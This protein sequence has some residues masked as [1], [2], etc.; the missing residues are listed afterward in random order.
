M[1]I[2]VSCATVLEY[3]STLLDAIAGAVLDSCGWTPASGERVLVKPNLVSKT[4][5]PLSCTHGLVV[6][7]A[8]TWLL[9][10]GAKV[11]VA[12]SPAFGSAPSVAR[13]AGLTKALD[14]LGIKVTGLGDPISRETSFGA[15]IGI[16]RTALE[17]DT[18]VNLP[19][20]KAHCQ[21]RI[22][23]AVKNLFGCVTGLRKA[24]A[25]ARFG[26]KGNQFEA[27]ILDVAAMLPRTISLVDAIHPMHRDGPVGGDRYELGLLAA[28]P[29]PIALDTAIYTLLD[30]NSDKVPLWREAKNR[31]LPGA[32][33][34]DLVF[35]MEP[36]SNFD[37]PGFIIPDQLRE[38]SFAPGRLIK[39]RVKS[40]LHRIS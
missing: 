32:D 12:D 11:T 39:G 21:M 9:D 36:L 33:F 27:M 34:D 2:P 24:F 17:T 40:L 37:A 25:H 31:K 14:P 29:S 6:R 16:S 22:T 28:S 26:E 1:L 18:I 35:P 3:E 10:R 19:K 7:A 30:I 23:G 8:C 38:V 4:G 20:L 5:A 13:A 15:H